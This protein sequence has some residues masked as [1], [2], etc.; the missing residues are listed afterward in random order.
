MTES[1]GCEQRRQRL[2][3]RINAETRTRKPVIAVRAKLCSIQN[4][5]AQQAI[6]M[7]MKIRRATSKRPVISV[8]FVAGT[9][10]RRH[11]LAW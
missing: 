11:G 7:P 8:R 1:F 10:S 2:P 3:I 9:K 4:P 5:D 6:I